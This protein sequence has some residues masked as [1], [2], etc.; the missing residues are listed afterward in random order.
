MV[1]PYT[2]KKITLPMSRLDAMPSQH[3]SALLMFGLLA[4]DAN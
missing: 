2:I 3:R 1:E 4:N